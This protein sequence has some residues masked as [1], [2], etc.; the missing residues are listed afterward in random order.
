MA[1]AALW[2]TDEEWSAVLP[3]AVRAPS[4]VPVGARVGA[5]ARGPR[6]QPSARVRRRRR[7]L[8]L[9]TVVCGLAGG[10]ALP[11]SATAGSPATVARR[12]PTPVV[13]GR[14]VYVVQPGDTLWSIAERLDGGGDPR[15]F[16]EALARE[17]GSGRVVAG[18]RI[19]IP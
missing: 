1:V 2:E 11:L 8:L 12:V 14:T 3:A 13:V 6:Q 15:P 19:A 17:T 18:E 10:L 4:G 16:A 7:R 5:A 9:G